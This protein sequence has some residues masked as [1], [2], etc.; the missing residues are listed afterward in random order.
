MLFCTVFG[1]FVFLPFR[2]DFFF[3]TL[4]FIY[5]SD[6]VQMMP[7]DLRRKAARLVASKVTFKHKNMNILDLIMQQSA[8]EL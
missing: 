7:P 8:E 3:V 6:L 1:L 4:G 2:V 5:Y